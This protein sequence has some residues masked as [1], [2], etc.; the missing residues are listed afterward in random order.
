MQA[1]IQWGG[2][3]PALRQIEVAEIHALETIMQNIVPHP[4]KPAAIHSDF[5]AIFVSLELI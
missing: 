3:Q 5:A 1:E 2:L 4:E